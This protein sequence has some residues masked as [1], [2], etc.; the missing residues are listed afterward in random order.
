MFERRLHYTRTLLCWLDNFRK[1][2]ER[3]TKERGEEFVRMWELYLAACG[4]AFHQGIVD[5]H[6]IL[7]SKGVNNELPMV[8]VV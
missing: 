3:I 7:M 1:H 8:R 4:A 2:R 5:L 6:Q